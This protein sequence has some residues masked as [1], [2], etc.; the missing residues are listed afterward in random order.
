M[1]PA[2]GRLNREVPRRIKQCQVHNDV[3][4]VLIQPGNP[5]T[6]FSQ[7]ACKL[8]LAQSTGRKN[9]E[10]ESIWALI[11]SQSSFV[12]GKMG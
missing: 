7:L 10:G 1:A 4:N 12:C 9:N 5:T 2:V 11:Y 6:F 3:R 8:A